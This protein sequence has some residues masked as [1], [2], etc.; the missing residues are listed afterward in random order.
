MLSRRV[1]IRVNIVV[2]VLFLL[3]MCLSTGVHVHVATLTT[4]NLLISHL[5]IV[6]S[7][8]DRGLMLADT[9][10][11]SVCVLPMVQNSR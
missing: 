7:T 11:P 5:I 8:I 4:I 10:V 6:S 3:D 9:A 2:V 1:V